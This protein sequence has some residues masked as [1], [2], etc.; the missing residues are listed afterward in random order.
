MGD[1]TSPGP[2][3][4][5]EPRWLRASC[6]RPAGQPGVSGQFTDE[7]TVTVGGG[8]AQ[9]HRGPPLLSDVQPAHLRP[10]SK[11]GTPSLLASS[12]PS[13]PTL[14]S[15]GQACRHTCK[16]LTAAAPSCPSP[17]LQVH[18][19]GRQLLR[20]AFAVEQPPTGHQAAAGQEMVPV[21][22]YAGRP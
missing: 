2:G 18:L 20:E 15:L 13:R 12:P 11:L 22:E 8:L 14:G 5:H 4:S 19:G 16:Q 6:P 21:S 1:R 10:P 17:G 3:R 7:E 9:T